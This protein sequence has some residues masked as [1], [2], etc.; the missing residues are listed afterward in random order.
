MG[1]KAAPLP[2]ISP[3]YLQLGTFPAAGQRK[4]A[5]CTLS[6]LCNDLAYHWG[7]PEALDSLEDATSDGSHGESTSAVI[8]YPPGTRE[9]RMKTLNYIMGHSAR[10][11]TG[12][13][14]PA[15]GCQPSLPAAWPPSQQVINP[16]GKQTRPLRRAQGATSLECQCQLQLSSSHKARRHVSSM[17]TC[18][19]IPALSYLGS[20]KSFTLTALSGNCRG[21]FKQAQLSKHLHGSGSS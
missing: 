12:G 2:G 5:G 7:I 4:R 13:T 1:F 9:R 6:T 3:L 16:I 19:R 21:K 15:L 8:H 18:C 17:E 14:A 20:V 11:C 10:N